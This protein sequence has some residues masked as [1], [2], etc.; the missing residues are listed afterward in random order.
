MSELV[1]NNELNRDILAIFKQDEALH[2][3]SGDP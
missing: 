3:A 1:E 2:R